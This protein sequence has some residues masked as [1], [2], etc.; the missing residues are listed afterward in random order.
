M[1]W[2]INLMLVKKW[3][4]SCVDKSSGITGVAKDYSRAYNAG[5]FVSAVN[6]KEMG[7]FFDKRTKKHID[8]VKKYCKKISSVIRFRII[9]SNYRN[10]ES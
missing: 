6:E 4:K 9:T 1:S 2:G 3:I 5:K 10:W 7:E 8:L